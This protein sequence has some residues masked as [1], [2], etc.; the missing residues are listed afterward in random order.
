MRPT[1]TITITAHPATGIN[2]AEYVKE[3]SGSAGLL[4]AR[5]AQIAARGPLF[6]SG[7]NGLTLP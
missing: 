5:A 2:E 7:A 6:Y 1:I 3:K 4:F